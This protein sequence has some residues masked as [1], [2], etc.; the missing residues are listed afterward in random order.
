LCRPLRKYPWLDFLERKQAIVGTEFLTAVIENKE[1]ALAT[2]KEGF[3]FKFA[4]KSTGCS[5]Y[6]VCHRVS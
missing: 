5:T 6:I 2:S 1:V 4:L 3:I